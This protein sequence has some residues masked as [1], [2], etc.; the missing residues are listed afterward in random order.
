MATKKTK[1]PG[2]I[3]PPELKQQYKEQVRGGLKKA[4]KV[5]APMGVAV[6]AAF[7]RKP[8]EKLEAKGMRQEKRA[9]RKMVKS[10]MLEKTSPKRSARLASKATTLKV[11]GAANR[12][13]AE[14]IA[15]SKKM[16]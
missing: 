1:G 16:K 6:V 7:K 13:A 10:E 12:K 2:P 9:A 11:K 3:I 14:E 8:E 4:A 15:K 5:I